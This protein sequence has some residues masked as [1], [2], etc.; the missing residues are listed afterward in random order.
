MLVAITG[1]TG[2]LGLPTVRRLLE[3]DH[4]VR[5]LKRRTSN[6]TS[7]K[8][9]DVEFNTISFEDPGSLRQA[10]RGVDVLLHLASKISVMPLMKDSYY[11][12]T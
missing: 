3:A 5:V 10:L 1:A 11:T 4:R 9:Y 6:I 7:I 8:Q 12:Q 2:H